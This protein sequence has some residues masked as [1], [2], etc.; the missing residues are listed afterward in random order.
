MNKDYNRWTDKEHKYKGCVDCTYRNCQYC[1]AIVEYEKEAYN[2]LCDLEDKIENGTLK[3]MPC[4]VGDTV[5]F[6]YETENN[7]MFIDKGII[8]CVRFDEAGVWFRATYERI[9]SYWH[10]ALSV[11]K[12]VFLTKAEAEAKLRKLKEKENEQD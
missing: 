2:R 10:T 3:F 8:R 5:W 1:D 6:V 4:K 9:S 7:T 12:T 11:G